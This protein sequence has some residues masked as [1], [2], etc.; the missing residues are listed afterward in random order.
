MIRAIKLTVLIMMITLPYLYGEYSYRQHLGTETVQC[1]RVWEDESCHK[2]RNCHYIA[3]GRMLY[4]NG[5]TTVFTG[6]Y[7]V[8][9]TYEDTEKWN[10]IDA[11]IE[12][13][14][15]VLARCA[16]AYRCVINLAVS[17]III[18]SSV[19]LLISTIIWLAFKTRYKNPI[20]FWLY[21]FGTSVAPSDYEINE[22]MNAHPHWFYKEGEER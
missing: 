1:I 4:D 22:F 14:P 8:G 10:F 18:I 11:T 6:N 17:A 12:R 15:S 13:E 21:W 2:G 16:Q 7:T 3:K 20:S 19:M 9:M 5:L